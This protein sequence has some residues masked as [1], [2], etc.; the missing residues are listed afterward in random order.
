MVSSVHTTRKVYGWKPD[1]PDIRDIRYSATRGKVIKLPDQVDLRQY[2]T[3][4][5]DQGDLGSCTGHAISGAME[6]LVKK[7]RGQTVQ[8]SRLFIYYNERAAE[9]TINSDAGAQIRTGIKSVK[10]FGACV[11]D[12]WG[13]DVTKFTRKPKP[14][15]YLDALK[16]RVLTYQRVT[17]LEAMLACLAAGS[18]VVFGFGVYDSFESD[19]V[20]QTGIMPMPAATER[21]LGG[22]AVCAVGYDIPSK[23]LI[24][25]NS[26][27]TD[28]G[29]QGYF[30]MPFGV[31]ENKDLSDDFWSIQI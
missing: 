22:H 20:A 17:G 13:Y 21:C 15:S 10:T 11:E 31:I 28:W 19:A 7:N 8:L 23:M 12:L 14:V 5:E 3:P 9:G 1:V 6:L 4:I 29:Q 26:W 2:C 24:V 25:R 18:P 30:K 27:G 16:H